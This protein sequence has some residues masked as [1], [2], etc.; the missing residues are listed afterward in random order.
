MP[1]GW[2]RG[3]LA[4]GLVVAAPWSCAQ[5]VPDAA[6]QTSLSE[7]FARSYGGEYRG[8]APG[9]AQRARALFARTFEVAANPD[10]AV[11]HALVTDW[12]AEGFDMNRIGVSAANAYAVVERAARRE[13]RGFYVFR[14]G[15][16]A[17]VLQAPH[18]PSDLHTG[19]IALRLFEEGRFAAAA[20]S[21]VPRRQKQANTG[22]DADLAHHDDTVFT[23]FAQA[24]AQR[25]DTRGLLQLHGFDA[26]SRADVL[27]AGTGMIVSSG[28]KR[29][30]GS[31]AALAARLAA[32]DAFG[33]RR[34][35]DEVRTLGGLT[36]SSVAALRAQG[37]EAL[38]VH[39]EISRALRER[40][41]DEA[42]LRGRLIETLP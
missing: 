18:R 6:T 31:A 13:G 42:G 15:G 33:A 16:G 38:F 29:L 30:H 1:T 10:E 17:W 19:E 26:E 24:A 34:Y 9:D 4:L 3:A 5:A 37:R 28:A 21:T 40:L 35:P 11:L 2:L 39:L 36:N 12:A 27:P 7:L 22:I 20:W 23:A 25:E 8:A 32:V 14:C 41:R